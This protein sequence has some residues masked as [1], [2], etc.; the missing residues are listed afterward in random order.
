MLNDFWGVENGILDFPA[1]FRKK[2]RKNV[3]LKIVESQV[4]M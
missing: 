1:I 2:K 4:I 3:F